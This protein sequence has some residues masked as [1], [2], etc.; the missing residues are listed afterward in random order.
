MVADQNN[1]FHTNTSKEREALKSTNYQIRRCVGVPILLGA[2]GL[3][4]ESTVLSFGLPLFG[5]GQ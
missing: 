1:I 3:F 2:W 5:V 4:D